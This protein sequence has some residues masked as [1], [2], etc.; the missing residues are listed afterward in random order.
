MS[1]FEPEDDPRTVAMALLLL[2]L[3]VMALV[4][5]G[6]VHA[7]ATAAPG[8]PVWGLPDAADDGD[9]FCLSTI[10]NPPPCRTVGEV[11]RFIDS[12]DARP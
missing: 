7:K 1:T 6:C 12:A 11:R 4:L 2:T 10:R 8:R 5:S 9:A 3:A